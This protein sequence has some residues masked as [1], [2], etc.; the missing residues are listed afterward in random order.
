MLDDIHSGRVDVLRP[1]HVLDAVDTFPDA[2]Q[3]LGHDKEEVA[4]VLTDLEDAG[5]LVS[6]T[7][8]RRIECR[9][10][11]S[12]EVTVTLLC[13]SC[14]SSELYNV[15]KVFCP[16]C[17]NP[18]Q[19]VL[20]D[21]LREVTCQKCRKPVKVGRLSVLGVEPLC[22]DCGTATN[23]PKIVLT[24]AVCSKRMDGADLLGGIGLA[25]Y[26]KNSEAQD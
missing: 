11:G 13:P 1:R 22:N 25:Y 9:Q 8:G 16:K 4:R 17:S 7:Y 21:D 20:V 18:F 6:K 19:A 5:E 2:E 12:H 26:A 23:D 15:Y 14:E 24:C 10:C 3:Y